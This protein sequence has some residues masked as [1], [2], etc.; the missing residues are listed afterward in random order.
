MV[1]KNKK[2]GLLLNWHLRHF[3]R[4]H[5]RNRW[6]RLRRRI[7]LDD[8]VSDGV[9]RLSGLLVFRFFEAVGQVPAEGVGPEPA[10][11]AEN[12]G[13]EEVVEVSSQRPERDEDGGVD[14]PRLDL[15]VHRRLLVLFR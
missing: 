6:K 13:D 7:V 1:K 11:D 9:V 2:L 10:C 4:F 15:L 5:F 8:V 12:R 3:V 14:V